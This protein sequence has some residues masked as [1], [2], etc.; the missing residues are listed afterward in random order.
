M[1]SRASREILRMVNDIKKTAPE[2]EAFFDALDERLCSESSRWL[3]T[4]GMNQIPGSH[5]LVLSGG[6]GLRVAEGID[7]G[8]LP[9]FPYIL[10][11]G[12]VRKGGGVTHIRTVGNVTK[13]ATFFDDSIYGGATYFIIKDW[14][15][16]NTELPV[17]NECFV[18]YDGCPENRPAIKSLFRYY[19]FF[20]AKPNYQF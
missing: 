12:G 11:K 16:E 17:P 7:N 3:I 8:T 14:I 9:N 18:I 10:F 6:M 13:N 15:L 2:G 19:N 1:K 20:Q 5:T 4:A